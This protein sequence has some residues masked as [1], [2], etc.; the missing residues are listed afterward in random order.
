MI[1]GKIG[2][3][4]YRLQLL[5]ATHLITPQS[6]VQPL[7]HGC[8]PVKPFDL[9]FS[10][11]AMQAFEVSLDYNAQLKDA[12]LKKFGENKQRLIDSCQR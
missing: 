11:R 7:F 3:S 5:Y 10:T 9:R 12:M 1:S 6:I 4:M 2:T 8:E